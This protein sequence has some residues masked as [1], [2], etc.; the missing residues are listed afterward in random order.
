MSETAVGLMFLIVAGMVGIG[1]LV[2][3]FRMA[4]FALAMHMVQPAGFLLLR[5]GRR[6]VWVA[7]EALQD[8]TI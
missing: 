3:L 4:Q 2:L 6:V 1:L 5:R 7:L 8:E